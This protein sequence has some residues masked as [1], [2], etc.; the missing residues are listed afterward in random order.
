MSKYFTALQIVEIKEETTEAYSITFI[1]DSSDWLVYQAGQYLTIKI[2]IDGKEYRRAYSLSSSPLTDE[3]L[4]ITIKR[5]EGGMVS[6]YLKDHLSVGDSLEVMRPMGGFVFSPQVDRGRCYVMIGGGSGITPLM[7]I[8]KTILHGEPLSVVY[9]WYGNRTVSSIIYHQELE[10]LRQQYNTRLFIRHSLSQPP[11]SWNGARGRLDEPTIYQ[12]VSDLFMT[13][14][15]RKQYYLC[16]PNGLMDA[17]ERA[18]DKH[19]VNPPDIHREWFSAAV[20][21]EEEVQ[22]AY[23]K[24]SEPSEKQ[25]EPAEDFEIR[26]RIDQEDHQLEVTADQSILDAA[27]EANLDPPY[28]CTAGIC[29][30]CRAKLKA[31]NVR[32]DQSAGLSQQELDEGYI[33]TCQAHPTESGVEVEF[34]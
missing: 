17:A 29:T 8:L 16:G 19:A 13:D 5:V 15:H 2:I 33:L 31:G 4:T 11:D 27:I 25:A 12:W 22:E 24:A 26:L 18:L 6:N 3:R 34:E 14:E 1:P 32:M 21:T 28:A 7:S 9:L 30:T 23:E 10:E 20:P